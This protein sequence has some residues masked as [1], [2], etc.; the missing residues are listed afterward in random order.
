MES[1][2]FAIRISSKVKWH[3]H[4][5]NAIRIT[6]H[7]ELI[8][9]LSQIFLRL[10]DYLATSLHPLHAKSTALKKEENIAYLVDL[11]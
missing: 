5:K 6:I 4:A 7:R 9:L 10:T 8:R 11:L 2:T 1:K 3:A